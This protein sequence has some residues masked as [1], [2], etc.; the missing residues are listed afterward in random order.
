MNK[1]YVYIKDES[2]KEIYKDYIDKGKMGFEELVNHLLNKAE[3]K[4]KV[5]TELLIRIASL[6]YEVERLKKDKLD[7]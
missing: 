4:D 2:L 5:I 6:E 1:N 7:T 3:N